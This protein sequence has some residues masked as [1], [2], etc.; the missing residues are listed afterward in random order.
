MT[1]FSTPGTQTYPNMTSAQYT[2]PY[3]TNM[4]TG[5]PRDA[6][7]RQASLCNTSIH[8]QMQCFHMYLPTTGLEHA[9]TGAAPGGD[10]DHGRQWASNAANWRQILQWQATVGY[11]P[12]MPYLHSATSNI[13]SQIPYTPITTTT[14]HPMIPMYP[15]EF[16]LYPG[17]I[18]GHPW[19]CMVMHGHAWSRKAW[20]KQG[21]DNHFKKKAQH[22]TAPRAG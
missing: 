4:C 8:V 3:A 21:R 11:H 1:A 6:I 20:W 5:C 9:A 7:F 10:A 15:R 18:H 22:I 16:P 2:A 13:A 14:R 19:S 17:V 12:A